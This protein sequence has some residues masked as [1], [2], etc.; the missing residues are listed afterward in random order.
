MGNGNHGHSTLFPLLKRSA[1]KQSPPTTTRDARLRPLSPQR[2]PPTDGCHKGSITTKLRRRAPNL[3]QRTASQARCGNMADVGHDPHP[4]AIQAKSSRSSTSVCMQ[5]DKPSSTIIEQASYSQPNLNDTL[6][7]AGEAR[8][9]FPASKQA[10]MNLG[11]SV[12]E[13]TPRYPQDAYSPNCSSRLYQGRQI[14]PA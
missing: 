12:G 1:A 13:M 9:A 5:P 3:R 6:H 2:I 14:H 8:E 10:P 4:Q 7:E 11:A